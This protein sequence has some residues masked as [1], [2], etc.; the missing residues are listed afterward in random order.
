MTAGIERFGDLV[1]PFY[2]SRSPRL[3]EIERRAMDRDG[4]VID[5]LDRV[6]PAGRVLDVG[7]GDGFTAERLSRADRVVVALEPDP[8]IVTGTRR[9][10]WAS[11]EM[12]RQACITRVGRGRLSSAPLAQCH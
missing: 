6:L 11:G 5:F 7:A 9:L 8:G 1:I 2:G 10:L 3:F 12:L 4:Q